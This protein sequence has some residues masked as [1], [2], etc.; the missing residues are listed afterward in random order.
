VWNSTRFQLPDTVATLARRTRIALG[1]EVP[2]VRMI[3]TRAT[4]DAASRALQDRKLDL[5]R[6]DPDDDEAIEAAVLTGD[7]AFTLTPG[8]S[9][10]G[11]PDQVDA[12]LT[13]NDVVSVGSAPASWPA[14]VDRNLTCSP[15]RQTL[16]EAG[17][18]GVS[19]DVFSTQPRGAR[20]FRDWWTAVTADARWLFTP[21]PAPAASRPRV[22]HYRSAGQGD[23]LLAELQTIT[24]D[25][26][27][28][29]HVGDPRLALR[30]EAA[31]PHTGVR[32]VE[33]LHFA[34]PEG[35]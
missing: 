35:R 6:L 21:G 5:T 11:L 22:L 8:G 17:N 29:D 28:V 25:V 14:V 34:E 9:P 13:G 30:A 26:V 12:L 24:S 10:D 7:L 16:A 18:V 20:S 19:C 27:I 23:Q 32:V 33:P 15:Q 31:R 4:F 2:V 1:R 3:S